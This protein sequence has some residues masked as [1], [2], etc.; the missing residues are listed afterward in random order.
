VRAPIVAIDGPAGV[1]KTTLGRK[2]A[3]VLGVPSISTGLMYRAV[4]EAALSHGVDPADGKALG[5]L[6][7]QLRFGLASR[8]EPRELMID[9]AAPAPSLASLEVEAVVSEVASHPTVRTILRG[10]QRRLGGTGCVME[11]RDIG[12]VVF[13]DADVKI[14][15]DAHPEIRAHRRKT[16]RRG[17]AERAQAVAG[18]DARDSR[19]TP[20]APVADSIVIDTTGL[21]VEAV[22]D[23]ALRMVR[24]RIPGAH[25]AWAPEGPGTLRE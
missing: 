3:T 13:P 7:G 17:G 18:R 9:G 15:L 6:A 5:R 11:G 4:A 10:A 12:S 2:L 24:E 22:F 20:L 23:V 19:T 16:E 21:D 8:G 25:I 14:Q 1:G